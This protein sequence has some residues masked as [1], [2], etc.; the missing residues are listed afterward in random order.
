MVIRSGE[1]ERKIFYLHFYIYLLYIY[2]VT[3]LRLIF[4]NKLHFNILQ[5]AIQI[6]LFYNNLILF[7]IIFN[8]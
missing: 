5:E 7:D 6:F 8:I 4:K 1:E 3:M 2:K